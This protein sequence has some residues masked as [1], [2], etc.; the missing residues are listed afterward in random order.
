MFGKYLIVHFNV[1]LLQ[2][3]VLWGK[4]SQNWPLLKRYFT[5]SSIL[6]EFFTKNTDTKPLVSAK[7][8]SGFILTVF[9]HAKNNLGLTDRKHDGE[10]FGF[11]VFFLNSPVFSSASGD[12]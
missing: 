6:L 10:N 1:V 3:T 12:I 2:Q 4:S 7:Q 5:M 8:H 11:N 9:K